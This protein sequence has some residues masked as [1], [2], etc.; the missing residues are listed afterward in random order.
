M[1]TQESA[2]YF[3]SPVMPGSIQP[4]LSSL[5]QWLMPLLVAAVGLA[6]FS[7][8]AA[9]GIPDLMMTVGSPAPSFAVGQQS[10]ITVIVD[11]VGGAVAPG[12]QW[13]TMTIPADFTTTA[14]FSSQG[15]SCTAVSMS[16][17]C[18][19][20]ASLLPGT[21]SAFFV[22]LTPQPS[23]A[24]TARTYSAAV[25]P[26]PG[27]TNV[28]D[29]SDSETDQVPG[30]PDLKVSIASPQPPLMAGQQS[31]VPV[32]I[33]NIGSATASGTQVVTFALPSGV[34]ASAA[35]ATQSWTCSATTSVATCTSTSPIAPGDST[36]FNIPLAPQAGSGGSTKTFRA[37]AQAAQGEANLA[38]N[39]DSMTATVA[40]AAVTTPDLQLSVVDPVP[41]LVAGQI[42]NIEVTLSNIGT[43]AADGPQSVTVTLPAGVTAPAAFIDSVWSCLTVNSV[44]RCSLSS[45]LNAGSYARFNIP[46]TPLPATAGAR[47]SIAFSATPAN[48]ESSIAN[49]SASLSVLVSGALETNYQDIWWNP[50]EPGWG[51]GIFNQ[52]D[53]IFFALYSYA[54]TSLPTWFVGSATRLAAGVYSG[55]MFQTSGPAMSVQPFDAS[56]VSSRN[57]GS[58][59]LTFT[60]PA[61]GTLDYTLNGVT[62]SHPIVRQTFANLGALTGSYRF[63]DKIVATDCANAAYVGV[64][65]SSGSMAV[66][67]SGSQ[68]SAIITQDGSAATCTVT[69]SIE[70]RGV[71]YTVTNRKSTCSAGTGTSVIRMIDNT[72]VDQA[73]MANAST[74]C[75]EKHS[76]SA[77][78]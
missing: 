8:A 18:T 9:T 71:I 14:A 1:T 73:E 30:I 54:N 34:L 56:Q 29:N 38:D 42:S 63:V 49:N 78:R 66:S 26:A 5:R 3:S 35:F 64:T 21:S 45:S 23:S 20:P 44:A 39:S 61:D 31:M 47:L 58:F 40:S 51:V 53:T 27:E 4:G 12:P 7:P 67:N 16:V 65:Y 28:A 48:G 57:V 15:W 70:Q 41:G 13:V 33:A 24:G 69:G 37:N 10:L 22:P 52:G 46:V 50:K 17:T 25:Q 60:G 72:V 76:M 2:I 6:H 59:T 77:V 62:S 55:S 75:K 43:A 74:G 11:N 36:W 32:T 19:S 68:Y